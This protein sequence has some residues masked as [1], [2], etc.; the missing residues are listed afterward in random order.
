MRRPLAGGAG[1]ALMGQRGLLG[2]CPHV[3]CKV[4]LSAHSQFYYGHENSVPAAAVSREEGGAES[5]SC[6]GR[7]SSPCT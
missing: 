2:G 6:T 5:H 3:F 4:T 7:L 1:D